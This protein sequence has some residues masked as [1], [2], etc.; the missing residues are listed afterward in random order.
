MMATT[1]FVH[2]LLTA[3]PLCSKRF[4]IYLVCMAGEE[5]PRVWCD[6][7]PGDLGLPELNLAALY[8]AS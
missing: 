8:S 5:F 7:T 3:L 6:C 2:I 1:I 4:N